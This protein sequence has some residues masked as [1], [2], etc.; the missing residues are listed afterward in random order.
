[1]TF[2]RRTRE[3]H[4]PGLE[5]G[6]DLHPVIH[7]S[8]SFKLPGFGIKLFEAINLDSER[9]PHVYAR[10]S[11][12][13]V[14]TLEQQMAALE[15]ADAG[16]AFATGMA[17]V[18]AVLFTLLGGG[19]HIV[20][21]DVAYAGTMELMGLHLTRFGVDTTFVDTSDLNQLADAIRGNTKLVFLET[22]AN[23]T[24]RLGDIAA[25]ARLA[26]EAGA[27]LVVDSTFASPLL[28]RP[29]ALGA[30]LVIHSLTKYL[31]GHG[32]SLGGIVLGNEDRI[33]RIRKE[34]LVHLGGAMSPF[35]A[36]LILRGL[37]TL[38]LR[39]E[40]HC[41][42]AAALASF[43]AEH[44]AIERVYYPGLESHPQFALAQKQMTAGG[45]MVA[46]RFKRGLGAAIDFAEK[47]KI[48]TYATSLGH[49]TSLFFY[50]PT[51]LY[52]D[53]VAYLPESQ[54]A[55]IREWMGEPGLVRLSP[56]L[57]DTQDL[58]SDL[59]QALQGRTWKGLIGPIFYRL[60]KSG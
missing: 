25:I 8:A 6:E 40:Q 52:L 26:H 18:S 45:G 12:P 16:V 44:S 54:K 5:M 55:G 51:D 34:M 31:N 37:Q 19:D 9:S 33:H 17:A 15:G 57:E 28:Q 59:S 49:P 23:P 20:A 42:T 32:D 4:P 3:V 58:I 22:P 35:N 2:S 39:M 43:L 1:M 14:R 24:L 21:S 56:G 30:D 46:F 50:Y 38:S 41:K 53:D 47:V 29:L 10:W 13:T 11:N 60:L 7:P 27:L 36:W 48:F